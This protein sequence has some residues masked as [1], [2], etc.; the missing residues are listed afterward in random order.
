[1]G[2]PGLGQGGFPFFKGLGRNGL[3]EKLNHLSRDLERVK[4]EQCSSLEVDSGRADIFYK[5][6]EVR[7]SHICS[8]NTRACMPGAEWAGGG[9]AGNM[10]VCG[11]LWAVDTL[12]LENRE[13]SMCVVGQGEGLSKE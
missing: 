2:V 7:V 10:W 6:A 3:A 11:I 5:D 12:S 8:E 4:N 9:V 13:G 1:M